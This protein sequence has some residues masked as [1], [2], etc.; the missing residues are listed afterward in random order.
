MQLRIIRNDLNKD[1]VFG[2]CKFPVFLPVVI[3]DYDLH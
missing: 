3:S 1:A 2:S